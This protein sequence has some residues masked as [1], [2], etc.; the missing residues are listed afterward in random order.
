[1]DVK[2]LSEVTSSDD[3]SDGSEIEF[4][5]EM[6]WPS[7]DG[8]SISAELAKVNL[9][10]AGSLVPEEAESITIEKNQEL[11]CEEVEN[12][13]Q[14]ILE[15]VA[16]PYD[17]AEFQRVAINAIGQ[18]KNLI[19]ISPTGSG[20][21]TI[22]LISALLL[23]KKLNLPKGVA[24]VTL[25]LSSIMKEK[26][27]NKI[28]TAAVLSMKGDLATHLGNDVDEDATLS[29]DLDLLLDGKIV[30]LFG[31]PESFNTKLGQFILRE[32]QKRGR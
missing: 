32:L 10:A 9:E 8:L 14:Q 21:M 7:K 26:M 30:T 24:I 1:M 29:C 5:D 4:G 15:E 16:L 13:L 27:S 19:L 11:M 20:K 2:D 28:C 31:H 25:P 22:P 18:L 12:H 23:R 3:D 17:L 6:V